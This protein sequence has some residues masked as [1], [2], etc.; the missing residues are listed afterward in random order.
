MRQEK[1]Q[2]LLV[3]GNVLLLLLG[4]GLLLLLGPGLLLF[5]VRGYFFSSASSWSGVTFVDSDWWG[6]EV[7]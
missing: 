3:R 7:I 6:C 2:S 4:P 1:P 5:L